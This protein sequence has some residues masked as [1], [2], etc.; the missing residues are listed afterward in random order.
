MK[1][2]NN[3]KNTQRKRE[4]KKQLTTTT[5]AIHYQN[6]HISLLSLNTRYT[7]LLLQQL[8]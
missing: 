1:N 7:T 5:P 4:K 2:D 3:K 6:A 8:F